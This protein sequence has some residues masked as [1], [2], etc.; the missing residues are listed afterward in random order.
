[1]REA[2]RFSRSERIYGVPGWLACISKDV[3]KGECE[4]CTATS[5]ITRDSDTM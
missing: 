3:G 4:L 2:G 5:H 1:M